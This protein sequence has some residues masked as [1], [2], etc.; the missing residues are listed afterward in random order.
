MTEKTFEAGEVIFKEMSL[1]NTMYHVLSGSADIYASYGEEQQKKLTE[2]HEG[3]NFGEM[4]ILEGW[5]RSATVIAGSEGI[6]VKEIDGNELGAFFEEDPMQVRDIMLKMGDRLTALTED[7]DE[8]TAVLRSLESNGAEEKKKKGRFSKFHLFSRKKDSYR[9]ALSKESAEKR[10]E[11]TRELTD[12]SVHELKLKKDEVIFRQ[13]EGGTYIYYVI[14]GSVGIYTDYATDK[15]KRL[16]VLTAGDFFG[17]IGMLQRVPRST[18][19]VALD[20][21][22]RLDAIGEEDLEDMFKTSPSTVLLM[23]QHLSSRIRT[24]TSDYLDLCRRISE[25]TEEGEGDE[26]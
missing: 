19:A 16:T 18:T 21:E 5:P 1:G 4:A 25:M 11:R 8:A 22:T 17:E 3:D 20:E 14:T 7:F 24:L 12:E 13:G 26:E 10:R 9:E 6:R 15:E 2:V 23:M